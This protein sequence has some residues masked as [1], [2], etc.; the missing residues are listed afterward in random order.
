M[1]FSAFV[2][3]QLSVQIETTY[4]P[5]ALSFI[6]EPH[7]QYRAIGTQQG[8]NSARQPQH[9][10]MDVDMAEMYAMDEEEPV[11]DRFV[12]CVDFGTT[13]TS[14]AYFAS[15]A[16]ERPDIIGPE[17]HQVECI[18]S[19]PFADNAIDTKK[20]VSTES[21]YKKETDQGYAD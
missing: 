21:W 12:I 17:P 13:F 16:G 10:A 4:P 19:Y 14:V 5:N 7:R 6:W 15:E 3:F 1:C 20:D 18:D 2:L 8:D 9:L 11:Q